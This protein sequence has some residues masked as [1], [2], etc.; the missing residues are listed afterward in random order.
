MRTI[1]YNSGKGVW[2]NILLC[3]ATIAC[4]TAEDTGTTQNQ[5][6]YVYSDVEFNKLAKQ[7]KVYVPAYSDIYHLD[8][9]KRFL[10]TVT[11]VVRN[12][13]LQDTV[14]VNK[15]DF[16]DSKGSLIRKY[17]QRTIAIGPLASAEFI[18]EYQEKQ[19]GAGASFII[20]WGSKNQ[21][22]KP[23]IQAVMIGTLSQ[24]GISFITEGIDIQNLADS[25]SVSK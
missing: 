6:A 20:D 24:Q 15:V 17:V 12:T 3:L 21:A 23:L 22:A 10:L 19:G 11:A 13:S 9:N 7:Q 8:G 2:L 16:L 14:Y 25:T 4:S 1:F 5:F 18:V